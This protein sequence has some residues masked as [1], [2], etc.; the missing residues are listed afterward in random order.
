MSKRPVVIG[1]IR[2]WNEDIILYEILEKALQKC[3]HIVIMDNQSTG[4]VGNIIRRFKGIH[5][6]KVT[7][8]YY[9]SRKQVHESGERHALYYFGRAVID[10]YSGNNKWFYTLDADEILD[11]TR[12]E[13]DNTLVDAAKKGLHGLRVKLI[14]FYINREANEVDKIIEDGS[15]EDM[16]KY[17][18]LRLRERPYLYRHVPGFVWK[19]NLERFHSCIMWHNNI[20]DY[21]NPAIW[22]T[23][24]LWVKHYGYAVSNQDLDDKCER[25]REWVRQGDAG[26]LGDWRTE[27]TKRNIFKDVPELARYDDIKAGRVKYVVSGL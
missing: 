20:E 16:R 11:C 23:S 22:G 21:K 25:Y 17:A 1:L 7:T 10:E 8:V 2:A 9:D 12:D 13:L 6:N 3:D 5:Q 4:N 14:N 18:E 19:L 27:N 24:N 15:F 26:H